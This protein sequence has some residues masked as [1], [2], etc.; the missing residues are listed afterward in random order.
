MKLYSHLCL[1][2]AGRAF[3]VNVLLLAG[4][5]SLTLVE[6]LMKADIGLGSIIEMLPDILISTAPFTL[7]LA[8]VTAC[9]QIAA[10]WNDDG[11]LATLA[12]SGLPLS[13]ASRPV[14]FLFILIGLLSVPVLHDWAPEAQNRVLGN[15]TRLVQQALIARART[16]WPIPLSQN[17][18]LFT[19]GARDDWLLDLIYTHRSREKNEDNEIKD[20]TT[21]LRAGEGRILYEDNRFWLD[22][23]DVRI[24]RV[25]GNRA[26]SIEFDSHRLPLKAREK[27]IKGMRSETA[28]RSASLGSD[29]THRF[30]EAHRWI[31]SILLPVLALTGLRLG[32]LL[33]WSNRAACFLAALLPVAAIYVPL[34]MICRSRIHEGQWPAD[35]LAAPVLLLIIAVVVLGRL[36]ERRGLQ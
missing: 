26:S 1:H 5:V 17:E 4:L 15:S 8:V 21:V 28:L 16:G 3:L 13:T 14:T 7:P 32:W 35:T 12:S 27:G 36:L 2:R 10:R 33:P 30:E 22:C 6:K 31:L 29:P 18:R 20:T 34:L 25:S 11:E 24:D 19:G 23:R 9:T